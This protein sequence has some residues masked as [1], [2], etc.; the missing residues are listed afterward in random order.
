MRKFLSSVLLF[1]TLSP[2]FLIAQQRSYSAAEIRLQLEKANVFGSVLYIAAHPDD[3]NTRL[4]S[5]LAKEKKMRTAYLSLT[6][7]E[8]GQNL[9]GDEKGDLLGMIRT[10]ELLAA[11]KIDGAEQYF[12]SGVDFG[13]SKNP[14]ETLKKW[15]KQK[16]LGDMVWVIRTVRPDVIIARFPTTGEGGHGHHTASAI[17]AEEAFKAA[18]DSRKFPEQLSQLKTWKAK[19]LLWN[20]FNFGENNTTGDDQ[21]KVDIGAYNTLLGKGYG[22]LAAE[23]RSQHKSQ[24]FGVPAQRGSQIEYF[25]ILQG[26]IAKKGLFEGVDTSANRVK[27]TELFSLKIK[28]ALKNF[29]ADTPS[30][31]VPI[32]LEAYDG[33]DAIEDGYWKNQKKKEMEELIIACSGLWFE[34]TA[35]DFAAA[36]GDQITVN[37]QVINRSDLKIKLEKVEIVNNARQEVKKVLENNQLFTLESKI[38]VPDFI[39]FSTPYWL[40]QQQTDGALFSAEKQEYVPIGVPEVFWAFADFSFTIEGKKFSFTRPLAYKWTDPIIGERYRPL[41]VLPELTANFEE[42]V[43]LFPDTATQKVKMHLNAWKNTTGVKLRLLAPEG[44][45]VSPEYVLFDTVSKGKEYPAVFMVKPSPNA[46][47]P[48][49]TNLRATIQWRDF[50]SNKSIIHI[51]HNHIPV[52]CLLKDNELKAVRLSLNK[53]GKNIG[54]IPGAGDEVPASLQQMGYKVSILTNDLIENTNLAEYDAIVTGVRAYNTN[55]RL[56]QYRERLMSYVQNGG[57]LIVQYT[58]NNFLGAMKEDIGPYPFKITRDRVTDENA[59]VNMDMPSHAVF[60]SPNRISEKDFDGWVQ[61]RGLYFAGNWDKRYETPMSMND[62]AET[63]NRG[64]LLVTKYGK[65]YFVYTGLSFFR[66]LPAG[67]PGAYRLFANILSLGK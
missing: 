42:Q 21:L 28:E 1:S 16:V 34:T 35:Q 24:G 17:L 61:E 36:K 5:W 19:R 13:Y 45:T 55:E 29:V 41:E 4:L 6:R 60:N 66:E 46:K 32:L 59:N 64:S 44:W 62:P 20:T 57:N 9:I 52:Q 38:K 2:A 11:R 15:D 49:E 48:S 58:T 23:S 25:K 7:G 3:E 22:E 43:C 30:K 50:K 51:N 31:I 12:T 53:E 67:V 63:L 39:P 26:P 54:Y 65:G 10:Q 40:K 56:I 27:G 8:G 47:V 33:L 37:T 18:G 14:E